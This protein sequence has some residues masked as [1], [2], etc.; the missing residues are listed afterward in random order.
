L[1]VDPPLFGM[2]ENLR[3]SSETLFPVHRPVQAFLRCDPAPVEA[4]RAR[5]PMDPTS[6]LTHP[7]QSEGGVSALQLAQAEALNGPTSF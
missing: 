2:V 3:V 1:L 4:F 5:R 6:H 7:L